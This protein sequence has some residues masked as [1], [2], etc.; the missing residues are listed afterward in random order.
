MTIGPWHVLVLVCAAAAIALIAVLAGRRHMFIWAPAWFA[1]SMR[2]RALRRVPVDGPRHLIF[3]LCDHFEPGWA[4]PELD[5]ERR[6]M[7]TWLDRYPAL[8]RRFTDAAGRN[9]QHTFFYPAEEYRSEHL[10]KLAGLCGDGWGEVEVHVHHD[11]ATPE[12]MIAQIEEFKERLRSHGFLGADATGRTRFAFIHGNWALDNSGVGGAWCGIN[13][14]LQVL[15]DLGCYADL[16]MPSAPSP[17]QTRKINSIYWATDDPRRPKSHNT[18]VDVAVGEPAQGDLLLIQGP[19]AF[20]WGARKRGFVP[21]V[22]NGELSG[23]RRPC[24]RRVRLWGDQR[25]GVRGRPEWVFVKLHTH[26]CAEHN[27]ETLFG[28]PAEEMHDVLGSEFNDGRAWQLH[29]VTAREMY[30]IIMAAQ[31]GEAGDPEE[32]RDFAVTPPPVRA[33]GSDFAVNLES[34][35]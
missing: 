1:G 7:D 30:N 12:E 3:C 29:Y 10:E 19:L 20:D 26:G 9:P 35:P 21:A 2:R 15:R 17:T 11:R 31:A 33:K 28:S 13:N 34:R 23:S 24:A 5:V 25:I 6:R 16:T 8:A 32:Y 22:E 18:G 14:E 27:M 4:R